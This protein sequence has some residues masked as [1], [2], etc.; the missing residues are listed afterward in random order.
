MTDD[1]SVFLYNCLIVFSICLASIS[2]IRSIIKSISTLISKKPLILHPPSPPALPI[3]GHLHLLSPRSPVPNSFQTLAF[4]YGPLIRLRFASC[5]AV[6]ISNSTIAQEIL[7]D[8]EMNFV[9][10]PQFGTS[11][12]DFNIYYGYEFIFSPNGNYWRFMKKLC[13]TELL[14]VQQVTNFAD[15]RRRETMKL[16]E[17]LLNCANEGKT[18]DLGAEIK[19]LTNNV[20]CSMAMSTR[21]RSSENAD[22][23]V[24]NYWNS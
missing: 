1:I 14:S 17:L 16:M 11:N 24:C 2:I 5:I 13:M 7:K 21:R 6:I 20:I 4:R 8:N 19:T 23:R 10:R 9:S 3:I 15:I 22:E 12:T 18:C